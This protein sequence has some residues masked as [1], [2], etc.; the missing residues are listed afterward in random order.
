[1]RITKPTDGKTELVQVISLI[2][3]LITRRSNA[4]ADDHEICTKPTISISNV[5]GYGTYRALNISSYCSLFISRA[6]LRE[7]QRN[8]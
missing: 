7:P 2:Y 5:K 8:L 6:D 1:M 4:V 3:P